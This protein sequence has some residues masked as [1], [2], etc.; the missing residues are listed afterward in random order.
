MSS[1]SIAQNSV[2]SSAKASVDVAEERSHE[3]DQVAALVDELTAAADVAVG[4]PLLLV[5]EPSAVA[6]SR[7]HE[8]QPAR[9][10]ADS[11]TLAQLAQR[12]DGSGG[13]SRRG[14]CTPAFAAASRSCGEVVDAM[15]SGLLDEDVLAG[16]DCRH[17][18]PC[19]TSRVSSRRR[20][21]RCR[22]GEQRRRRT[23]PRYTPAG[24]WQAPAARAES[25]SKTA[26]S[27]AFGGT[28]RARL[29]TDEAAPDDADARRHRVPRRTDPRRC[30]G[31]GSATRRH[32][33]G[34]QCCKR[35]GRGPSA[36]ST[37]D[38][39]SHAASSLTRYVNSSRNVR[40]RLAGASSPLRTVRRRRRSDRP[41]APHP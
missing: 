3:I 10:R 11:T 20:P 26:T 13:C 27:R 28:L 40:G 24:H 4:A 37:P 23:V 17:A 5:A 1:T 18:R 8:Q 16:V 2:G 25:T 33:L 32:G 35:G 6:V 38:R 29:R 39:C 15:T 31:V 36:R 34:I 7:P 41:A 9:T 14:T 30:A 12:R 19:T 22:R 21:D